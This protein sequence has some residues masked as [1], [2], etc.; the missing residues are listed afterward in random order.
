MET[1]VV[2]RSIPGIDGYVANS[3][4]EVWSVDREVIKRRSDGSEYLARLK[5]RKL[6]P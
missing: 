6:K 4:G 3:L 2:W 5:G 1:E